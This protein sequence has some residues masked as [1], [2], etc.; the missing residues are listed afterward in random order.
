MD[1]LTFILLSAADGHAKAPQVQKKF[2]EAR[3]NKLLEYRPLLEQMFSESFLVTDS[4]KKSI[5][6]WVFTMVTQCETFICKDGDAVLGFAVFYRESPLKAT[7]FAWVAPEYRSGYS[8]GNKILEFLRENILPYA[9]G[10][11]GLVKLETRCSVDNPK[12]IKFALKI[13]FR[14]IGI[15]RLDFQ[16]NGNLSDTVILE[17]LNPAFE[18]EPVEEV[19]SVKPR[20]VE[21]KPATDSL[22]AERHELGEPPAVERSGDSGADSDAE[23]REFRPSGGPGQRS[24]ES[25]PAAD[26]VLDSEPAVQRDYPAAAAELPGPGLQNVHGTP[27]WRR[28]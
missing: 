3:I 26:A 19:Q 13:G 22:R 14:S 21:P 12:A 8:A 9:Y 23:Q 18:V 7:F 20:K 16:S 25:V 24:R 27:A 5:D 1:N 15:A 28:S 11:M 17:R 6:Q 2:F 10:K 4:A